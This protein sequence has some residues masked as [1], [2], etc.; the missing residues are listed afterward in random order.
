MDF[1][2]NWPTRDLLSHRAAATPERTGLIDA[3]DGKTATYRRL[4][5]WAECVAKSFVARGIEPGDAIGMV[6]GTRLGFADVFHAAMRLRTTLFLLNPEL[7][8]SELGSQVERA[9]LD[10]LICEADT[11][12]TVVEAA[13]DVPIYTFDTPEHEDVGWLDRPMQGI[14]DVPRITRD[15]T[16]L[17][18]FTSGT[19]GG[20]KCVRLTTGNLMASATA[21]AFRLGV[22]PG[23][24]WLVCL[25]MYHMG[26]LAPVVRSTLYGTTVVLQRGF[27]EQETQRV[28]EAYDVTGVS[29]VPTMLARLLDAGWTPPTHLRF[30]LVG[31]AP[32]PPELIERCEQHGVPIY[33]SY[34][35]T[36]TASQIATATPEQ[37]FEHPEAVGNPLLFTDVCILSDGERCEPGEPG[38]IVVRGPTVSPGYLGEEATK[39]GFD[40]QGLYTGDL[41]YLDDEG[42]LWVV[43]RADDAILTGGE[44]VHPAT[45]VDVVRSHPVVSDAAVVGLED[46]EWGERVGALV[47]PVDS[48]PAVDVEM[49]T[50]YCRDQLARFAVP[51]T[52][53]VVDDLPRTPSG[54][55]DR[56]ATVVK[57]NEERGSPENE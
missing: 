33:P 17:G 50:E 52:W 27:D 22:N 36:E 10:C 31:G 35:A 20:P 30:V 25:P 19:T 41:G 54:T 40:E 34:G 28:I 14:G 11:E 49:L 26:G 46:P 47:V 16:Q 1:P 12:K 24:R 43:G 3:D 23:D 13:G 18:M 6:A 57:L 51:K 9:D 7:P 29:L 56:E 32:T 8:A 38:E 37:A 4:D 21:S 2:L 45:V 55:I 39:A 44:T 42:R 53:A 48:G 5:G 15:W